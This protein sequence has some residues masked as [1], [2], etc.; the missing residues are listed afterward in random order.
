VCWRSGTDYGLAFEQVFTLDA[1]AVLAARL[2]GIGAAE[3]TRT[4]AAR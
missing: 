4:S 1:I 2:Q 3:A